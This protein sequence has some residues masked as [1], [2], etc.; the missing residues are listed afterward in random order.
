MII[1]AIPATAGVKRDYINR[2]KPGKLT[3]DKAY[4]ATGAPIIVG[5]THSKIPA[6]EPQ[7][8]I[9]GPGVRFISRGT[10]KG[11]KQQVLDTARVF[12]PELLPLIESK[13]IPGWGFNL[14]KN[15]FK[16][17]PYFAKEAGITGALYALGAGS[18]IPHYLALKQGIRTIHLAQQRRETLEVHKTFGGKFT[19]GQRYQRW[20]LNSALL[21]LDLS[22][23]IGAG[24]AGLVTNFALG[25]PNLTALANKIQSLDSELSGLEPVFGKAPIKILK[26]FDALNKATTFGLGGTK[27]EKVKDQPGKSEKK[28]A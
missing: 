8:Q 23:L 18:P 12:S 14:V 11:E 20:A 27:A 17:I 24:A 15:T 1:R 13:T 10:K 16:S 5:R 21:P 7:F 19:A 25:D 9:G 2:N 4:N 28:A 22:T 3:Q 6:G 26:A